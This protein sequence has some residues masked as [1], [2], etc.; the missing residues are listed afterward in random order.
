[1]SNNL[2]RFV[3]MGAFIAAA[4]LVLLDGGRLVWTVYL[5]AVGV[6][7]GI[8]VVVKDNLKQAGRDSDE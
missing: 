1:M 5:C 4:I 3:G 2:N 7:A 8:D 6:M